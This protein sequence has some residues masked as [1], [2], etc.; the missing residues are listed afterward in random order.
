MANYAVDSIQ[1]FRKKLAN[2]YEFIS[3]NYHEAGHV[4][5]GLLHFMKIDVVLVEENK[6]TKRVDGLTHYTNYFNSQIT[7]PQLISLILKN[8]IC[9]S[10]AGLCAEKY[11]FKTISGSDKFPLFLRDG[12]S[13]DTISAAKL[14][15]KFDLAPAGKKRYV[16]KQ[17]LIKETSLE[18]RAH[19]EAISLIAH[20]LFQRKKLIYDDLK[21]IL[22]KKSINKK[23]W[24]EQFKQIDFIHNNSYLLDELELKTI[25][26]K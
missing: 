7:D 1:K 9:M 25:L 19:W 24:K 6:K 13:E 20:A 18:L 16:L 17:K 22:I 3:T 12:S 26:F 5:Y 15:N 23:F 10:Y 2:T 8:E 21:Q 11:H 14:I 4:I